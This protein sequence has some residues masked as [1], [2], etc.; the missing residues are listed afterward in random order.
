MDFQACA[1]ICSAASSNSDITY[2]YMG[3]QYTN[4]CFCGTSYGNRGE[5]CNSWRAP[6]DCGRVEDSECDAN[7]D[8]T[9][10]RPTDPWFWSFGRDKG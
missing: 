6:D 5:R 9:P 3:L 8:G 2:T 10:V 7:G 1:A 4:E